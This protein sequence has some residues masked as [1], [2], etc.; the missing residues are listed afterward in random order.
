MLLLTLL[1]RFQF[2]P[3]TII[4]QCVLLVEEVNSKWGGGG[5]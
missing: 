5:D 3:C 4:E 1:N 2:I